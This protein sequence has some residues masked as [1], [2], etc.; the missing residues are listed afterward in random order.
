MKVLKEIFWLVLLAVLIVVPIRVF[1][2]QPFVVD[3][4]SMYP[5]FDNGDY[6][7]ID[8]LSYRLADP[9]RGDVVVFRY[10]NNPSLFYLK[11]VIGL[12]GE[13]IR[14]ERGTVTIL[15][16]DGS[17]LVLD[18]PYVVTEDATYTLNATLGSEQY[19]VMGDN[20]PKSSDSRIWGPLAKDDIIGKAFVR[21]F[22][23]ASAAMH[24]G[25]VEL[26]Q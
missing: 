14:I 6:L 2:A 23:V 9:E 1:I 19:F 13:T 10:P 20:R 3:G 5:T 21:I 15:R 26:P 7:I 18:E 11:R 4:L 16:T 17:T 22:P 25:D 12:P 8:E 24:P